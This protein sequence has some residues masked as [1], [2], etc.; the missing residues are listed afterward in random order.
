MDTTLSSSKRSSSILTNT[1]SAILSVGAVVWAASA[2][3]GVAT[4]QTSSARTVN[5][6]AET[7]SYADLDLSSHDGA[8]VL[9]KRI[10]YAAKR[11]C[12]PEPM[13]SPLMPAVRSQYKRCLDE[14]ADNAVAAIK[15]P[16]VTAL[17]TGVPQP[18]GES[19]AAR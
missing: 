11:V 1:L 6:S 3:A 5:L 10:D 12:G 14:A 9:L 13:I 4:A 2:M 19:F 16:L 18:V 7:V 15:A 8:R 17:H